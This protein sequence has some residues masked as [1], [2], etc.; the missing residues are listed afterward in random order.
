MNCYEELD[1]KN[2]KNISETLYV[3]HFYFANTSDLLDKKI[4]Q[5]IKEYNYCKSFNCPPF[6]SLD[7]TPARVVDDFLEIEHIMLNIRNERNG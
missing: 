7:K 4:Q 1:K 6:P 2:I 3:E 5:R